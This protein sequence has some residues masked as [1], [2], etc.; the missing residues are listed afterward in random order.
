MVDLE[1]ILSKVFNI[2]QDSKFLVRVYEGNWNKES[3]EKNKDIYVESEMTY[4]ELGTK[5]ISD[6]DNI[7][8]VD[9]KLK[10]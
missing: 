5:L 7:K 8:R 6:L 1:K 9:I 3:K 10:Y 2:S 4:F